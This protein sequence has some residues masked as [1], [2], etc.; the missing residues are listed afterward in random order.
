MASAV[1]YPLRLVGL[2]CR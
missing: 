2:L 1:A